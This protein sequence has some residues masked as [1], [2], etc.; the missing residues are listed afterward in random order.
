[1][2]IVTAASTHQ[3][4]LHACAPSSSTDKPVARTRVRLKLTGGRLRGVVARTTDRQGLAS[5]PVLSVLAAGRYTLV[6]TAGGQTL[7]QTLTV[8]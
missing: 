6:A 7:S 2:V 1:M 3:Y 5:F 4:T 8:V